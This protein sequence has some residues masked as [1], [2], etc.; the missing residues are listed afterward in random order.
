MWSNN[1]KFQLLLKLK[2]NGGRCS[3]VGKNKNYK[4][5][6]IDKIIIYTYLLFFLDIF[7]AVRKNTNYKNHL[8]NTII[9]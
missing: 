7:F 2:W 9:A 3:A 8:A 5:H 1:K 4:K 6:F